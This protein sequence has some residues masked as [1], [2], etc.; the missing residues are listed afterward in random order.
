MWTNHL[1]KQRKN[2]SAFHVTVLAAVVAMAGCGDQKAA[3]PEQQAPAAQVGVVR[4][5]PQTVSLDR[6][7]TARAQAADDVEI[8]ARVQ[9]TLLKR[10]YT[11]GSLVKA[12][13]VLFQIDPAP[14][15]A[16][17]QQAEADLNRAQAQHR[18]AEREWTRT[19]ALFKDNAVS[20]RDRDAALSALEL[21]QAGVATSRAQLRDARIQLDYTQVKAPISGYAGMRALSE[22]NLV[23]PN[24]LLTT[25]RKLDP[26]HVVF[27][28]PEVDAIAHRQ[29]AQNNGPTGN[30]MMS[31]TLLLSSGKNYEHQG[32]IDFTATA[33]DPQTGTMQ[34]RATFSNPRG[35]LLPG[36]FVR[37]SLNGFELPNTILVPPQAVGQG[38][39]GPTVF[40]VDDK[41][42][43]QVRS[44]KLGQN[45]QNGQ[46]IA[47]GVNPGDRVI[48]EGVAKVRAGNPVAPTEAVAKLAVGAAQ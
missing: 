22:G 34:A 25:I 24:S 13:A 27:S 12:G 16:R 40:V 41:N 18:Q 11:E 6:V 31:A 37:V 29:R 35:L 4:V 28:M 43:A 20:A 30:Q 3:Q 14:F 8:R 42:V 5:A 17:V 9:G 39:Q 26:V 47:E 46:I 33:M 48:V 44:V 23:A 19:S 10:N 38:P 15:E 21:A 7:Y 32:V 2:L 36:Q 45:T 1:T